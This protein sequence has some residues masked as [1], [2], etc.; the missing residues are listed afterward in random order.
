MKFVELQ[1]TA[2]GPLEDT[3]IPFVNGLNVLFGPNESAKT[4]VHAALFA[5]LCGIRRGQG[6]PEREDRAFEARHR[7]WDRDTWEVAMVVELADGRRIRLSHDLANKVGSKAV[8][9]ST[10][11]DISSEILF[12]GSIDGSAWVG[13]NR[14]SFRA[15]ACVRQ[16][17]IVAALGADDDH[18]RDHSAL[19]QALQRAA[20]TAGQ[21]DE[22][23]AAALKRLD[24]FWRENVGLDD[25]RSARRPYRKWKGEVEGREQLLEDARTAHE[26]Y[27]QLLAERD[28]AIVDRETCQRAVK[29]AEAAVHSRRAEVSSAKAARA[30]VLQAKY[31][32]APGGVAADQALAGEATQALT[33]WESAPPAVS[34][35]GK[36]SAALENDLA[37]LP[38]RPSGDLI[39]AQEVL[40]AGSDLAAAEN[41]LRDQATVEEE[42]ELSDVQQSAPRP[43]VVSDPIRAWRR[44]RIPMIAVGCLALA[45]IVAVAFGAVAVGA[46]LF[47]AAVAAAAASFWFLR[48]TVD[49]VARVEPAPPMAADR[50][51]S[52]ETRQRQL[53]QRAGE[54]ERTLREAL[55]RRGVEIGQAESPAAAL[56]RYK[57]E[58]SS[59]EEQDRQARQRDQLKL[60]IEQRKRAEEQQGQRDEAIA[61]L[62]RVAATLALNESD[63]EEIAVSL[64]AWH[65]ERDASSEAHDEAQREWAEL[66]QLLGGRSL[67]AL[68]DE[69]DSASAEAAAAAEGVQASDMDAT[70]SSVAERELPRLRDEFREASE[71]VARRAQLAESEAAKLKSVAEAEA[72]LEASQ[73]EFARVASL[74]ATLQTTIQFLKEAQQ[75]VYESIAP[76]LTK[77]LEDW[78]PRVAVSVSN[79]GVEA[80]YNDTYV[81]PE[82]LAVRVRR[83]SGQWRNADLL[84]AGTKEQIYLLLRVALTEH[85]VKDGEIVPL[86]L[87][88]VT[89]QCD[90]AR[91]RAVLELLLELSQER[92]IVLFTH[93][94]SVYEWATANLPAE[95]VQTLSP[96]EY[97]WV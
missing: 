55:A 22:T 2:F 7:P 88:E 39:P 83:D 46:V 19:Q 26:K 27:L 25:A 77:T 59:R 91:R 82:G 3:T 11:Q 17:E 9:E 23:A 69:A 92:Q 30:G 63:P 8:D 79:D 32:T 52:W 65:G 49:E 84:S 10:G 47:V 31:P 67:K 36:T 74:D 34:L 89:A 81:D 20:T 70:D 14:R 38:E 6:Q 4:T 29:A 87:D 95:A 1:I 33:L 76:I 73:T 85:L 58:C 93:E 45:G 51:N 97:A 80:R 61:A 35:D 68:Q 21:R 96:V 48:P 50:T 60:L 15:T 54:A 16:A 90:S 94:D 56:N 78:L 72:E 13:L 64:R 12:E 43:P 53:E 40:D 24:E 66:D 62:T 86:L 28:S 71:L 42:V 57:L 44:A 75:K 5:G 37:G 41:L 18:R